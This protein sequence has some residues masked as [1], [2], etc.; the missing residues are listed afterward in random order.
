MNNNGQFKQIVTFESYCE[1]IRNLIK[2]NLLPNKLKGDVKTLKLICVELGF[3][4]F[5]KPNIEKIKKVFT[6]HNVS[7]FEKTALKIC[8]TYK[9]YCL[10]FTELPIIQD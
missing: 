10:V 2:K 6:K 7:I 1:T 4:Q 5:Y 8:I 9:K 3:N